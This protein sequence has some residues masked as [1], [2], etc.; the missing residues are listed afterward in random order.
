MIDLESAIPDVSRRRALQADV[1][2]VMRKANEGARARIVQHLDSLATSGLLIDKLEFLDQCAGV[3]GRHV[4][5]ESSVPWISSLKLPGEVDLLSSA[6][7]LAKLAQS[8]SLFVVFDTGPWT[9]MRRWVSSDPSPTADEPAVVL[10]GVGPLRPGYQS[11]SDER[12]GTLAQVWPDCGQAALFGTV[13][14]IAAEAWQVNVGEL[15]QQP[16]WR[17]GGSTVWGRLTKP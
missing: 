15:L 10:D 13:L 16:G 7:L 11:G 17:H 3:Y 5:R 9:A 12:I 6:M 2:G 14:E 8:R 1:S 4:I